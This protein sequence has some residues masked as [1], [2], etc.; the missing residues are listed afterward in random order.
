MY[1]DRVNRRQVRKWIQESYAN[2]EGFKYPHCDSDVCHAPGECVYCDEIPGW[3]GLRA[4]MNLAYTGH[5]PVGNQGPCPSDARRGLGGAHV[6][7]GNI[8]VGDE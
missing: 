1:S 3:Q 5:E 8:P 7:G 2:G 4:E 6:W